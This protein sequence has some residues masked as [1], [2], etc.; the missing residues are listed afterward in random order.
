MGLLPSLRAPETQRQ[1]TTEFG[2]YNHN[3]RI[4]DAEF[5]DMENMSSD[6][7]PVVTQR[8]N[9]IRVRQLV[10]ANGLYAHNDLC[11]VEGRSVYYGGQKVGEVGDNR[12]QIIGMGAYILIWPDKVGYNT[13]T[14]EFFQLEASHTTT[15]DVTA[16]LCQ[17][18]GNAYEDVYIG[19]TPPADPENGDLWLDTS[20][21]PHTLRVYSSTLSGWQGVPTTYIKL[22]A[23]GIGAAF[24]DSDGIDITGAGIEAIDGN[25]IITVRG[26]D[27][28]VI[29]GILDE[30]TTIT[31]AITLSRK[32]PDMDYLCENEN[33]IWGCSSENH[34]IYACALGNPKVWYRYAGISTDSFAVTIGSTG[35]FTGCVAFA[36]SVLFFKDTVIHKLYGSQPS[37][38]QITNIN[39][40]GC[41]PG[42][43]KS[44]IKV[45]ES[46]YYAS[47][48]DI[49]LMYQSSLPSSISANL[50]NG[51]KYRNASAGTVNGKYYVSMQDDAGEYWMLVYDESK[52]T[53]HKEDRMKAT[54]FA[55]LNDVMYFID[56]STGILYAVNGAFPSAYGDDRQALEGDFDWCIE[57]GDVGVSTPDALYVSRI[58]VRIEMEDG[59]LACVDVMHDFESEWREVARINPGKKRTYTIP[60]LPVRCDTMRIRIH[61]SGRSSIFSISKTLETGGDY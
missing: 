45:N 17:Q 18:D 4:P 44:L 22:S 59:S 33:R 60:I 21:A 50:G 11:W 35:D 46:L 31:S 48:H 26:D 7:F 61:G 25:H 58:A 13:N 24:E 39:C 37:N 40:R 53:W 12:K 6:L 43:E 41:A 52:N 49:L 30:V 1:V 28:I 2:G 55:T 32:V 38:Y 9:R 34:E 3:L 20:K 36:G 27:F 57:T 8:K 23:S 42:S 29:P 5:Y 16:T 15:S 51:V 10:H 47:T 19:T 14:G 54:F 56:D